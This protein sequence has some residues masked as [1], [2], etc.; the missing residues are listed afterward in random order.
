MNFIPVIGQEAVLLDSVTI[1]SV[2]QTDTDQASLFQEFLD[3]YGVVKAFAA[4][5]SYNVNRASA[6]E[7]YYLPQ[8][9]ASY[10]LTITV[11]SQTCLLRTSGRI[12]G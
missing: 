8:N 7:R 11:I 4:A 9:W 12:L 5:A 3:P 10:L 6:C 1:G 2:N